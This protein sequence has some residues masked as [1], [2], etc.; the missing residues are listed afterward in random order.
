[1]KF[2]TILLLGFTINFCAPKD[3]L[4]EHIKARGELRVVTRQALTT[5]YENSRGKAGLEYDLVKRFADA[6]GVKLHIEITNDFK[7]IVQLLNQHQVDIA[8]AGLIINEAENLTSLRFGPS[9]QRVKF[10]LIYR[11]GATSPPLDL[12]EIGSNKIQVVANS[13][14]ARFMRQLQKD[15]PQLSW[16][17]ITNSSTSDLLTRV[18]Q[19]EIPYTLVTSNEMEQMQRFYPELEAGLELP[20]IQELAWMFT[21][22]P[23]DDS[24]YLAAIQFFQNLRQTGELAQLLERYYGH[25]DVVDNFD[26]VNTRV[27][28]RHIRERL[29]SYRLYFEQVA[30]RHRMDWRFLAAMAYEESQWKPGAVS[31]TGVRGLMQ[32]TQNA[33][34]EVGVQNREDPFESIEGG[35]K[36]FNNIKARIHPTIPEP[37]RTWFALAAYNVGLQHLGDAMLITTQQKDNPHRWVDVK[38]YLPLL[39]SPTLCG[40]LRWGCARGE[41]PVNFVKR[42]RHY[43]DMLAL[44]DEE[45]PV[46]N[47]ANSLSLT[48]RDSSKGRASKPSSPML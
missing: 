29:P 2:L 48:S 14:H 15:T 7:Q 6:L 23:Q 37:D 3:N 30:A 27:F 22:S 20:E 25:V 24:L 1:M 11:E 41:E 8:A 9:Y 18:W 47:S 44:I 19:Q 26:Y 39:S 34:K 38:Q 4:L 12:E 43:Y 40:R 32:L 21:R 42:V 45:Q 5:Y 28:Y 35:A 16:R 17:E 10:Q 13:P 36:Y 46:F 33:A 31:A